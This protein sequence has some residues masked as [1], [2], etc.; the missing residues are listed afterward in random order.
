MVII[1]KTL[2]IIFS[3]VQRLVTSTDKGLDIVDDFL[4]A[5]KEYSGEIKAEAKDTA[6]QSQME[7]TQRLNQLKA[8]LA[9]KTEQTAQLK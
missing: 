8:F 9:A 4:D 5:G 7:R 1:I 2:G 6:T 3:L